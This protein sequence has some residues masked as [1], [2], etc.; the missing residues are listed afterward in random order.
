[1]TPTGHH[2]GDSVQCLELVIKSLLLPPFRVWQVAMMAVQLYRHR[3]EVILLHRILLDGPIQRQ[4]S[5]AAKIHTPRLRGGLL[6]T[7]ASA[8]KQV[9]T[10]AD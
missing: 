6:T 2:K 8:H 9:D 4:G 7:A 10:E 3:I 1:M 5:E